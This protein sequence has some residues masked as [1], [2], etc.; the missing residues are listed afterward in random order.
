MGGKICQEVKG[1]KIDFLRKNQG[2]VVAE[3]ARLREI[4]G[5][6]PAELWRIGYGAGS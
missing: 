1:V 5:I 6:N 3:A 2:I 4:V